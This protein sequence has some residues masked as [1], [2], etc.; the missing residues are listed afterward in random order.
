MSAASITVLTVEVVISECSHEWP[1]MY[2]KKLIAVIHTLVLVVLSTTIIRTWNHRT[3]R[4]SS[5]YPTRNTIRVTITRPGARL[6]HAAKLSAGRQSAPAGDHHAAVSI[7]HPCSTRFS[8]HVM[9]HIG[10]H[11]AMSRIYAILCTLPSPVERAGAQH[12]SVIYSW[13]TTW[14]VPGTVERRCCTEC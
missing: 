9:T 10:L 2:N 13:R 8:M 1:C 6:S 5:T 11:S 4:S 3:W 7:I 12:D 14:A